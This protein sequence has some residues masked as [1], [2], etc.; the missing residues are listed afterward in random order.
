MRAAGWCWVGLRL[1]V[2]GRGE[3]LGRA[4]ATV[5]R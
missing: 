5:Y 3:G 1:P 2:R 4:L